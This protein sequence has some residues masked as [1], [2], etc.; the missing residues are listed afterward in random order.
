[1]L[2]INKLALSELPFPTV[3]TL[4]QLV[5]CACCVLL[6]NAFKFASLDSLSWSTAKPFAW[7][8]SVFAFGLYAN[9]QVLERSSIG[10]VIAARSC[11][12]ILVCGVD[13]FG[14]WR[15]TPVDS[16]HSFTWGRW[17]FRPSV[18]PFGSF[19]TSE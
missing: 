9:M 7:Y 18:H 1:M 6:L 15:P 3:L 12:P 2:V 4:V 17:L 13:V 10:I 5:F 14:V 8:S 16:R 11:L 19:S